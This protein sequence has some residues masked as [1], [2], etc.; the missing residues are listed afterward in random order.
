MKNG[1]PMCPEDSV[2]CTRAAFTL[3]ELLVVITIIAILVAILLPAVQRVRASAR[4][5]Q[6]KSNLSEMGKAIKHYEGLGRGNLKIDGWQDTLKPYLDDAD[7]VFF[8]PADDNDPPSYALT[9]KVVAMGRNDS[10]KITIIESD[11]ESISI[12][13]TNCTGGVST[14]TGAPVARH[15]GM[16]NAILYDGSVRSFEPETIDL[17][18]TTHEPLVIWWLPDREH[19][20]VCG[21]VVVVDDTNSLPGPSSTEPDSIPDP[22]GSGSG[23]CEPSSAGCAFPNGPVTH[24][25]FDNPGD[26]SQSEIGAS[27]TNLGAEWAADGLVGGAAYFDDTGVDAIDLSGGNGFGTNQP[28]SVSLWFRTDGPNTN[29][30]WHFFVAYPTVWGSS[31]DGNGGTQAYEE[32]NLSLTQGQYAAAYIDGALPK[33]A[34]NAH[35]WMPSSQGGGLADSS[36]H[37]LVWTWDL[38][39]ESAL[40]A[41]AC[42][43][44]REAVPANLASG[45]FVLQKLGRS[46]AIVTSVGND[47]RGFNGWM[48][49]VRLYQR[50]LSECEIAHL[51]E[52]GAGN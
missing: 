2:L 16:T 38:A 33:S 24:L 17:T 11:D 26:L 52:E 49:Q 32:V 34:G 48:D 20:L 28:G 14:I 47:R 12:D 39:G 6:S 44:D 22:S 18:D 31:G 25:A 51:Y 37:H 29:A 10:R 43:V 7:E 50:V 3:I 46:N 36:W 5:T 21:T 40:Y 23:L 1:N 19:G 9:N 8:D 13:N 42:E 35:L 45:V 30:M 41:D 4:S 27:G 15:S